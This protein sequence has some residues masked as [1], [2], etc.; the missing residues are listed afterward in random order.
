MARKMSEK[1]LINR[2]VSEL[3]EI[4]IKLQEENQ[5]LKNE[6]KTCNP[7]KV[8]KLRKELAEETKK[9]VKYESKYN[10]IVKLVKSIDEE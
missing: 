3:M 4:I 1:G 5:N 6:V 2:P 10:R 7:E 8:E 9:R